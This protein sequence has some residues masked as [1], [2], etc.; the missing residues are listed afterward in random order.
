MSACQLVPLPEITVDFTPDS[1]DDIRLPLKRALGLAHVTRL[2][3]LQ[4]NIEGAI[5]EALGGIEEGIQQGLGELCAMHWAL[6]GECV[7]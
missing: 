1:L 2:A 3:C 4:L 5:V 7:P 6:T